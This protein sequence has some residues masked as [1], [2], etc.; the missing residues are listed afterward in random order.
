MSEKGEN[1]PYLP[2]VKEGSFKNNVVLLYFIFHPYFPSVF[3]TQKD[4]G[5]GKSEGG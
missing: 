2:M 4:V 3:N 5:N 1:L